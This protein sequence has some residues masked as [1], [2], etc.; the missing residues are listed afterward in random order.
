[1]RV[2]LKLHPFAVSKEFLD[3]SVLPELKRS[4]VEYEILAEDTRRQK[5]F[6]QGDFVLVIGGDGTFLAGALAAV[7]LKVPI[8]GL[9]LGHLGFLCQ[10]PVD[11]LPEILS[12]LKSGTFDTEDRYVLNVHLIRKDGGTEEYTAL[13]DAVIGKSELTRLVSITCKLNEEVLGTFKADGVIVSTATG[14]TAYSLSAGGP[15]VE[16]DLRVLLIT[17]ICAHSLYA[18]PLVVGADREVRI[19]ISKEKP[20]VKI[21]LDGYIVGVM[22]PDDELRARLG[23]TPLK[24]A[25]F[26]SPAFISVLRKKFGWGFEF[27]KGSKE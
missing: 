20:E 12:A 22:T 15:I 25:R 24:V 7:K 10:H 23:D 6:P 26:N 16:P 21:S 13:N 14:S 8:V 4:G 5:Q 18:K 17:P 9:E 19:S 11:T 27:E 1:M 2:L 3:R